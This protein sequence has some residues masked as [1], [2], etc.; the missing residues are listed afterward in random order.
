LPRL[1]GKTEYGFLK[2][3]LVRQYNRVVCALLESTRILD[4][5][6]YEIE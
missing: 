3:Y 4:A 2:T 1:A 5:A 6:L